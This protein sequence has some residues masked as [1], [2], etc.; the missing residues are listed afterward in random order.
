M[1]NDLFSWYKKLW[2]G[3]GIGAALCGAA[4]ATPV[5]T[6]AG[7]TAGFTLSQFA[8]QF[9]VSGCCGPL[10]IAFPGGG[11]V[12]VTDY[13]GNVRVFATDA[14]GQHAPAAPVT[15]AYGNGNAVGLARVG[16]FIYMTQQTAGT[17]VRLNLDGTFNS[18]VVTGI[19]TATG[20]AA[21]PVTGKLYVSDCCSGSGI[22]IVDPVA[23]SKVQFKT[24]SGYDGLS[25]SSDGLT[26][27]AEF[28]GTIVG[29]R[30]SDGVQVFNSGGISG[31]D[32]TEL[33][34]GTLAGQIFVNTNSGELWEVEL[35]NPA[36]KVLVVSGGTRGDFV[37]AD[38]NGSLLF[39]QTSD[40]WRLT[41]AAGGC[42][43]AA[44]KPTGVP[45]PSSLALI[46]IAL[47][48]LS[49]STQRRRFAAH[50][51]NS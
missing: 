39:T 16:N 29:Y 18:F 22:W 17:V 45:E 20:I 36:N 9:P 40:I 13:P 41:P 24:G 11:K 27:Y 42:I 6:V 37:T 3:L 26:L 12:L 33:G 10:G 43:G 23:N 50:L 48:G 4:H 1:Q 46:A 38:P 32:G 34:A 21:N 14:D 51:N 49:R 15:Q 47:L 35:A 30:I 7:V 25:V 31:A 44:C 8:D 5:L 28:G 2:V 19:S